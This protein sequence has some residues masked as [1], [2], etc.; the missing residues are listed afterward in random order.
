MEFYQKDF[1]NVPAIKVI[2]AKSYLEFMQ[3][4]FDNSD[5]RKAQFI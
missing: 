2:Y 1:I 3:S 4:I 5:F